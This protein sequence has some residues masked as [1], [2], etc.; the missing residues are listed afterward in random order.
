MDLSLIF[1]SIIVVVLIIVVGILIY[2]RAQAQS[3][4]A[5]E[6]Q[7]DSEE[8]LDSESMGK[9]TNINDMLMG[10]ASSIKSIIKNINTSDQEFDLPITKAGKSLAKSSDQRIMMEPISKNTGFND[11]G[12][13]DA[14]Y[15]DRHKLS[16]YPYGIKQ[17]QLVRDGKG[18]YRY[19]YLCDPNIASDVFKDA[20]TNFNEEG[21]GKSHYLDRHSLDC[22]QK[23]I[24]SDFKLNRSGNNTYRYDYKCII[25]PS[26]LKCRDVTTSVTEDGGGN[27][28]YLDRHNIK[29]ENGEAINN[30]KLVRPNEKTIQYTYK[31]CTF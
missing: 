18:K 7:L 5:S 27:A 25:S 12:N 26:N 29:C 14:V 3:Q 24:I 22:G 13:G 30:F 6:V 8:Q 15:L 1:L 10:K 9:N 17:F 19:D 20:N 31:C 11:E 21:G 28:M 4:L 16:C 2:N 23:G